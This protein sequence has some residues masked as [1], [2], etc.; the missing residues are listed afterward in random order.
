MPNL[1]LPT[2]ST[3]R[4]ILTQAIADS[5][6]DRTE[7]S[8]AE[9]I[10]RQERS[11]RVD[12]GKPA[13]GRT[14]PA[15]EPRSTHELNLVVRT[16][17]RGRVGHHRA[18][19][20]DRAELGAAIRRALADGR[21]SPAPV[22]VTDPSAKRR[23]SAPGSDEPN[24]FWDGEIA[25]LSSDE[26]KALLS[27]GLDADESAHLRWSEGRIG[28]A[29]TGSAPRVAA[30]TGVSLA[31]RIGRGPAT[32]SAER[33]ARRL[34]DL[35]PGPLLELARS[36]SA[37]PALSP[38]PGKPAPIVLAPRAAAQIALAFARAALD[39]QAIA[40]AVA[41]GDAKAWPLFGHLGEQVA[42]RRLSLIDDATDPRGLALPFDLRGNPALPVEMISAGIFRAAAVSRELADRLQVPATLADLPLAID[43]ERSG[44]LH[45]TLRAGEPEAAKPL[46]E[47][48]A[49]A[50]G[51]LWIASL[52]PLVVHDPSS[53]SFRAVAHGA[54]RIEGG[55]IGPAVPNLLWD[56]N[57]LD[58]FARVSGLGLDPIAVADGAPWLGAALAP[59]IALEPYFELREA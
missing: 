2:L 26:A 59:E 1:N 14:A 41:R 42:N 44:V 19:S 48:L 47:L 32:G 35:G 10:H 6:A 11:D 9:A 23:G 55:R 16:V 37:D 36:R 30:L 38:P 34:S 45:P 12:G 50:D 46:G 52:S 43:L 15:L 49:A 28:F 56:S 4:E 33:V 5:P 58:V 7:I 57:L 22:E 21:L 29:A 17:E 25:S 31:L 20:L 3:A 39:S 40:D 27:E 54:R 13:K 24:D 18:A 53:L 51:G 8:W